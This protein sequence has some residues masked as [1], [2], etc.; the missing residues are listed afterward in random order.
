MHAIPTPSQQSLVQVAARALGRAGL[1]HAYGH[2]SMRLDANHFLVCAA[3]PMGLIQDE[4]GTVV[5]VVGAL[6]DGVLG[7]VRV[8]QNT[9]Q[10]VPTTWARR[11][12]WTKASIVPNQ[13][14]VTRANLRLPTCST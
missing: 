3:Q 4:E 11:T 13:A 10:A 6:P 1:V 12:R 2:C 8:H 9:R 14:K 5:S 7:E